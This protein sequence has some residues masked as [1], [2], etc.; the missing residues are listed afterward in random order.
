VRAAANEKAPGACNTG[1]LTNASNTL[2]FA[3]YGSLNQGKFQ[4]TL[5][6]KLKLDGH[7]V[8]PGQRGNFTVTK[9]GLFHYCEDFAALKNFAR[10]LGVAP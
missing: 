7:A 5:V 10:R 4:A 6:A 2:N 9:L 3:S 8:H 1:G